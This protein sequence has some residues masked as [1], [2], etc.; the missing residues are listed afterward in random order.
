MTSYLSASSPTPYRETSANAKALE[1]ACL[2]AVAEHLRRRHA[3][4]QVLATTARNAYKQFVELP[5][6]HRPAYEAAARSGVELL[7]SVEPNLSSPPTGRFTILLQTDAQGVVGDVRDVL[8]RH[9]SGWELGASVKRNNNAAKHSRLSGTLDFARQWFGRSTGREYFLA[10]QTVFDELEDYAAI[11]AH[12][13]ALGLRE[14]EK[15]LRFYRPVL[16]ALAAELRRQAARSPT[17]APALLR[18]MTG[19]RDFYK[20]IARIK[21]NRTELQAFCFDGELGRNALGT[22]QSIARVPRLPVPTKLLD[23]DFKPNSHNTLLV[24]FNY[25]WALSLRLHNASS[26]VQRSLKLDVRLTETPAKMLKLTT[27]WRS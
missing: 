7:T 17:I 21:A 27:T 9:D 13:S 20:L 1:Y 24:R 18:Y 15:A 11:G 16:L 4:V 8:V 2:V 25:N 23:I 3:T 26:H 19:R 6:T 22:E 5:P 14:E 10:I 12:W